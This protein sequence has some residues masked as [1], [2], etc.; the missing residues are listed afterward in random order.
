MRN[1]NRKKVL[2]APTRAIFWK[3]IKRLA[4]P[5][6]API[7]VTA[8]ELQE[9]FEK[10]L[11][12]SVILPPQFDSA[13]HK[14]NKVLATLLPEKT[15]DTTPEA[16]FTRL[17]TE[18]D[19]GRLKDHIRK[20]SLDSATGDDKASYMDLLQIP[21]EDLAY[22]GSQYSY[23]LI[24]LESCFLKG[25]TMLVHWRIADWAESHSLI[26]PWQNGFRAGYRTNNNPFILRCAKEW[27]RAH[28]HTLYVAAVDVSNT[29]P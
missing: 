13:Q 14:I 26:P 3:E 11:N 7:S 15:E 28:G 25:E 23:R 17:W 5:K 4:D 2:D 6:P 20:H 22:L 12:P 21:N 19:I 1:A 10:R 24:A 29:F 16:F 27:A 18:D 8:D 9:V